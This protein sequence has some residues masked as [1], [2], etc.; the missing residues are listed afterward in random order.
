MFTYTETKAVDHVL[1]AITTE[2]KALMFRA[3]EVA[4]IMEG[5]EVD[6]APSAIITLRGGG[7]F[8]VKHSTEQLRDAVWPPKPKNDDYS[9]IYAPGTK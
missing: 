9:G 2:G 1:K 6:G 5:V 4:S 7:E 3:G 8:A